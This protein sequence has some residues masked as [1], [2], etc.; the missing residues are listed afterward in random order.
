[1]NNSGKKRIRKYVNVVVILA[2]VTVLDMLFRWERGIYL[3]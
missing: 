2:H 3:V 1:M